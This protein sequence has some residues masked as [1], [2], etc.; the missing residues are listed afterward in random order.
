MQKTRIRISIASPLITDSDISKVSECL[1]SGWVSGISP[2]VEEFERRFAEYCGCKYGVAT[3]SGTTALHLALA[4]LKVGPGDEV[5]IPAFTM[6]ATANAVSYTGAKPVL[7]DAEAETWN[8]DPTKIESKIGKKTKAIMPV[9]TYGHPAHMDT[10]REIAV[11]HGLHI[12]E[13]AAEA[14]GAEYKARKA[15]SLGDVGCFS[16]YANKIITTGEGGMLVTN[17]PDV[18]ERARWLRAHAFGRGGKHFYHEEIGF[19]YRMSG[20]QAA[21]GISQLGRLDLNVSRRRKNAL[22]Y[23]ELLSGLGDK[24]TLPP[25]APWAKNVYWM[26][27][28]LVRKG[29]GVSRDKLIELLAREGIESRTFFYPIHVQPAYSSLARSDGFPVADSLS[30]SG[31][32]LPSGND[33]GEEQIR[34]VCEAVRKHAG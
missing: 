29:F 15:G 8:I 26:Y 10:I 33:L 5:I 14:H 18:A 31:I 6:I 16:F 32:N 3:N 30:H 11:K 2:Y 24:V 25:E 19:G 21:L 20:L 12:V 1:E 4:A 13:D 22:L 23:N 27:S 9:D 7:V 34:R 28:I 17:D